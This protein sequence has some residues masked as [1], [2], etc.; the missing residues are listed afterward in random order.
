M[1]ELYLGEELGTIP[2]KTLLTDEYV[3]AIGDL[4]SDSK[5]K[6]FNLLAN[7]VNG[8]VKSFTVYGCE[9]YHVHSNFQV[10]PIRDS[11][12]RFF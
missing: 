9:L 12:Y 2:A 3:K 1:E 10:K 11:G 7:T 6:H 5:Y 4:L 8:V